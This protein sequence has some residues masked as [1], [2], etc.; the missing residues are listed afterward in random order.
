MG[1]GGAAMIAIGALVSVYGYLSAN[2]L[3]VPRITFALAEQGDFP[4]VFAS[5]HAKFRTP[6]FSILIFA[7]LTWLLALFGSFSWNVTLSAVARLAYYGLVCAALPVLRRKQPE[8]A[9][10]RLPG[11]P[12]FAVVGVLICLV[13][14]TR[15]DLTKSLILI[16]T[17]AA[18]LLNWLLVRRGTPGELPAS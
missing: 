2:M 11:G 18:A 8:A 15:V 14:V 4:H 9:W 13:L 3:A 10:F 6:Y 17:V 12:A 5:V 7:L 16:A 1:H